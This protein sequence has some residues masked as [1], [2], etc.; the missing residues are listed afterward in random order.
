METLIIII[1][2]I[3]IGV[4]TGFFS[5]AMEADKEDLPINAL[6]A[7]IC[8][9]TYIYILS[10]SDNMMIATLI[11]TLL[12]SFLAIYL[13][14]KRQK[15]LQ[16]YLVAGIIPLLPGLNILKMVLGFVYQDYTA[17]LVNANLT[18]QIL[19]AIV[20]SIIIASSI[21]TMLKKIKIRI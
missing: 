15:P 10:L 8:Y 21:T 1:K 16:I 13:T 19:F 6:L 7:S 5:V 4:G 11:A 3:L 9:G 14:R 2:I 17:I 12:V 18:I 20:M